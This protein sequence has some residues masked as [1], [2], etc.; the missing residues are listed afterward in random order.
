MAV[1][2]A[3][4]QVLVV[5]E[6]VPGQ[7]HRAE[8]LLGAEQVVQIGAAVAGAGG[9]GAG[10]VERAGIVGEAGVAQVEHAAAGVGARGAAGAGR[11]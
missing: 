11:A 3:A 7:Q 9:A 8:H 6:V 10:R 1:A 5:L 2:Q 4:H